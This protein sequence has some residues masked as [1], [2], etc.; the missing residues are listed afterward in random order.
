LDV[1]LASMFFT[2]PQVI[3]LS[4]PSFTKN[5]RTLQCHHFG[6]DREDFANFA[7]AVRGEVTEV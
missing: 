3:V 5:Q 1:E 2:Q 6:T 4:E 7:R